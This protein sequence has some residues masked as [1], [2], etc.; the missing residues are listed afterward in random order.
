MNPPR[1]TPDRA[2]IEN[3]SSRLRA[4]LFEN[5]LPFW[6]PNVI[7]REQGG[8]R[9]NHDTDGNYLGPADKGIVTQAR[10][11]WFFS[12]L[13]RAGLGTAE[14]LEAARH[15]FHFLKE[16]MWD[17]RQGGFYWTVDASGTKPVIAKKHLYGQ[18]F[19]LYALSEYALASK[20]LSAESLAQDLFGLIEQRAHDERHG[21][22]IDSFNQDWST[23]PPEEINP[24]DVPSRL[25]LMNT[26]LHILEGLTTY[27]HLIRDPLARA[28]LIELIF[29]QSNTVVRKS[30]GGCTDQ[31]EADWTPVSSPAVDRIS[32]GH[33]VENVWLLMEACRVADVYISP[34]KDLF[35]TL[36]DYSLKYG[37][38]YKE[39]GFYESGPFHQPAD[40]REKVWWV[41]AETIASALEMTR[42]TGDRKYWD[43]FLKTLD[44]VEKKQMDR[45]GGDWFWS[46]RE[47]G[48]PARE[49]A[50]LWKTAYHNGRAMIHGL[51]ILGKL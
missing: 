28:R 25:K 17:N 6:Y 47:D 43:C 16:R 42:L 24:I 38:D 50:G 1:F 49:K 33:D 51:E 21:G 40:K 13:V 48:S 18:A 5:I 8:Y 11:V 37:F 44:W 35:Q 27:C 22:Y 12:R 26:H 41:Q 31:Y 20:D 46:I 23:P 14:H 19:A 45:Q 7:D 9:L 39:G 4:I 29:I 36:F 30:V 34:L 10:T 3:A 2:D 15:G 32:Y